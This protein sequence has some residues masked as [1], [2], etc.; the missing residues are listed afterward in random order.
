MSI[1]R[2]IFDI[3]LNSNQWSLD[4]SSAEIALRTYIDH[5]SSAIAVLGP[6]GS[7]KSTLFDHVFSDTNRK[8]WL[9]G[10]DLKRRRL[11]TK[12]DDYA[13]NSQNNEGAVQLLFDKI[14]ET[15]QEFVTILEA[16]K[17]AETNA[18]D[19]QYIKKRDEIIADLKQASGI[20]PD[21]TGVGDA[22]EKLVEALGR[23]KENDFKYDVYIVLKGFEKFILPK[24]DLEDQDAIDQDISIHAT[25]NTLLYNS[26]LPLHLI[27]STDYNVVW[28][29]GTST[30]EKKTLSNIGG[31]YVHTGSKLLVN[32]GQALVRMQNWNNEACKNLLMSV[33]KECSAEET[34][35]INTAGIGFR[36]GME[37]SGGNPS[38]L[39][40]YYSAAYGYIKKGGAFDIEREVFRDAG[41]IAATY[42]ET[43]CSH[44]DKLE[45][46]YLKSLLK[47]LTLSEELTNVRAE[48]EEIANSLSIFK[49]RTLNSRQEQ[50]ENE[51]MLLNSKMDNNVYRTAAARLSDRGFLKSVQ[52]QVKLL[53]SYD[54]PC[55]AIRNYL[56]QNPATLGE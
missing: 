23:N 39:L 25:L 19:P 47:W 15:C 7:G 54:F 46:E 26:E 35:S 42:L 33:Q 43:W 49:K 38:L 32:M 13:V 21:K 40:S 41:A 52:N 48:L 45:K 22:I 12:P 30:H 1:E 14:K 31:Q 10:D 29:G 27:V 5:A 3:A 16:E 9:M 20:E 37:W 50:L 28:Q 36:K 44:L 53:D 4:Q 55:L 51:R 18:L 24:I 34:I 2:N 6:C 17:S 56:E 11:V 8:K